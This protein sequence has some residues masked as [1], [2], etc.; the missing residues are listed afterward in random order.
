VY[1]QKGNYPSAIV[2]Y[3]KLL[4]ETFP[5]QQQLPYDLGY[6]YF[7]S[8]K[9]DQAEKYFTDYLKNPKSE[10]KND[11]ELRLADINYANND[12]DKAIA[13]YDQT[14]DATDYTL[15]Q[16]ALALGFKDDQAAKISNLKQLLSKYPNS[17]YVDDAQ[18]EIGVAYSVQEDFNNSTDYFG[19]VVKTS[20]DK[21]LVANASIYRAQNYFDQ[22]QSDKALSELVILANNTKTQLTPRK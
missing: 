17:E 14:T 1:Y 9:F 3:E 12:L 16:K 11:A 13:I 7:K 22:N 19:K 8:K 15:Y 2:R 20:T 6:A 4:N 10:F 21:D 5:E 18:Y